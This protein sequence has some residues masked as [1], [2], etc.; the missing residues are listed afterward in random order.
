MHLFVIQ[1]ETQQT[2]AHRHSS[3]TV[4]SPHVSLILTRAYNE[5]TRTWRTLPILSA[6]SCRR[7]K[8][9]SMVYQAFVRYLNLLSISS[10]CSLQLQM[11]VIFPSQREVRQTERRYKCNI[12]RKQPKGTRCEEEIDRNPER[13]QRGQRER[14]EGNN[15]E[16]RLQL[17]RCLC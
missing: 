3:A 10:H 12:A 13:N 8:Y 9:N 11:M 4:C 7:C 2:D 14:R 16:E 5:T 1:A 15:T 6:C 17:K